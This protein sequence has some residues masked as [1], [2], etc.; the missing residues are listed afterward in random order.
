[1]TLDVSA[2]LIFVFGCAGPKIKTTDIDEAQA[3]TVQV[4]EETPEA[5]VEATVVPTQ[6]PVA[7]R[8][9]KYRVV[10]TDTLWDISGLGE[11]MSDPWLWPLLY[12]ANHAEIDDPDLIFVDQEFSIP[13]G[14]SQTDMSDA[15]QD[16]KETPRYRAHSEPRQNLPLDYLD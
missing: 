3:D 4:V 9:R 12:K 5:I 8:E 15:T 2:T 11:V 7:P 16:S 6:A 10:K 1:M 14:A 13:K